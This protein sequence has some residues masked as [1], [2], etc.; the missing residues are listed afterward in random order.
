EAELVLKATADSNLGLTEMAYSLAAGGRKDEARGILQRLEERKKR[1]F[2][3]AYNLAII[4]IVLNE[5]QAA[6]RG[7]QQAYDEHD[8]AMA[9]LS[10]DPRLDP[11][12]SS[13]SFREL[14]RKL[15]LP[16]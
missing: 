5:D 14:V 1:D 3:P 10:T 9:I 2:V 6:L 7:L 4:H 11:L 16:E 12:R 13:P 8:W 15:R